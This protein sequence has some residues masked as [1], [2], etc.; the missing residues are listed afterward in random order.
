[1]VDRNSCRALRVVEVMGTVF[2]TDVRNGPCGSLTAI[3]DVIRWWR[4][5]D[6]TFS[7]FRSDSAISRLN[8]G[9][10]TPCDCAEEVTTILSLCQRASVESDGY[11]DAYASGQLDPCG[12]VKGWSIEVASAMLVEAGLESHCING[13]GDVRCVGEPEPGRKW[14]VGIADPLRHR[15]LAAAVVVGEGAVATSGVAERGYHVLNPST[16]LAACE[17]ASV[18]VVG[19]DLTWAD[20]YATAAMAMGYEAG[21]WLSSLEGYESLVI[22]HDGAARQTAGF[23]SLTRLSPSREQKDLAS[24]RPTSVDARQGDS[25]RGSELWR[26]SAKPI[27]DTNDPGSLTLVDDVVWIIGPPPVSVRHRSVM[28]DASKGSRTAV[29]RPP[30]RT[31]A[32]SRSAA[33]TASS[34]SPAGPESRRRDPEG[35]GS[36]AR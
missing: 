13:G 18:T 29:A 16:G 3:D 21:E 14:Q 5:V 9:E 24:H 34:R 28:S 26:K 35:G 20:A 8:R 6:R 36:P 1:M 27:L 23:P 7:P 33:K 19:P 31:P 2:S 15:Q 25:R 10:L 30:D 11:F 32:T 12:I 22:S 17:L 4:W